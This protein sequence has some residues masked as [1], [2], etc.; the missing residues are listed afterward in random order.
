MQSKNP[1]WGISTSLHQQPSKL[2]HFEGKSM[3]HHQQSGA[4]VH[5]KKSCVLL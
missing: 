5:D 1:N 4:W 3:K 2:G